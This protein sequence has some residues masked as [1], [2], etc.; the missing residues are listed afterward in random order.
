M[1]SS[2]LSRQLNELIN[3]EVQIELVCKFDLTVLV[4]VV[5]Q[6][7]LS[8]MSMLSVCPPNAEREQE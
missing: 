7:R 4:L 1:P 5:R 6:F 8:T 3:D 2:S